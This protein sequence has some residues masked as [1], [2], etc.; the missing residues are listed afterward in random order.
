MRPL[1]SHWADQTATR[2]IAAKPDQESFVV[3]SGV[4]PSGTAHI[5]NFREVITVDLV[6][7]ALKDRGRKVRFIYSW[8]DFDTFRKVPVNLPQQDM[9]QTKLR[10]PIVKVPDAYGKEESYAR[11]NEVAFERELEL[12]GISPEYIYQAKMYS[13]G[14][15][16]EQIRHALEQRES[17]REILN[18]HRTEPLPDDWL[19]T[20]IYCE[21]CN[22]DEMIYERYE[23]EWMYAYHCK[24]CNHQATAD[25]RTTKNLKLLWRVDWPMRWAYEGVD[26]E[27]GGKDHSSEGGSFDTGK[28]IVKALWNRAPPTYLQYDFVSIKGVDGKMSSSKGVLFTIGQALEVYT[29]QMVRWIFAVQRANH[30]FSI[31]FDEDVIKA[32]DEFDRCEAQA[33]MCSGYDDPKL[34]LNRRIYELSLLKPGIPERP[35]YRPPFRTLC[36]RLQ[37][38]DGD[39]VRTLDKYYA[40]DVQTTADRASFI[41]R[42]ALAWN[43][44]EHHAPDEFKYRLRD[45]PSNVALGAEDRKAMDALRQLISSVDLESI[46]PKDLNQRIYDD[47]IRVSGCDSKAFFTATYQRLIGRDQ[48]PR[49]PS[50]LKE[51]GAE[52]LLT[53]IV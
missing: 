33:Y 10:M 7:R 29:P 26:F 3:A 50:F 37:I 31:A 16:A 47:V 46:D 9:L 30:D 20:S 18:H 11:A 53:L 6:A 45:E 12:M 21:S 14:K 32:Y 41:E 15:Y 2:L 40:K 8:D 25:I 19:P 4:T 34:G 28:V 24:S 49:L 35:P 13:S 51:I 43:W 44:L 36:N 5:G 42:A 48:G 27:P 23:G 38:C 39:A 1:T 52:R 17:I 22:R